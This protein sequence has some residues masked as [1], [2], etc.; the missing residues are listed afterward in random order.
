MVARHSPGRQRNF[1]P[2]GSD[3]VTEATEMVPVPV[4]GRVFT[5]DRR[6]R[7]GDASPSGR[8]RLDALARYLQDVSNDDTRDA[9]FADEMGWV[10]RRIALAI[11]SFP[12]FGEDLRMQTF[13]SGTGS[14]WAERRVAIDGDRGSRVDAATLWVHMDAGSGRPKPLPAEFFEL[15]GASAAGRSVRP[16]LTHGEPPGGAPSNPWPLRYAD[17]DVLGHVNNA[18]Y[19]IA[20][21]EELGRRRHLRAPLVAELEYRAPIEPGH[22]VRVA[23]RDGEDGVDLWFLGDGIVHATGRVRVTR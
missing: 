17:F 23:A 14:R 1:A 19:W 7:L 18:A 4:T 11:S 6:V 20:I 16:R 10:V 13:C 22:D 15:F 2:V 21:E 5:R 9:G 3:R 12:V 8:L